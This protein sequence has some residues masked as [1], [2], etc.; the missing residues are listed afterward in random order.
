MYIILG[1]EVKIFFKFPFSSNLLLSNASNNQTWT[2]I[3]LVLF[4]FLSATISSG[5]LVP[6]ATSFL[7]NPSSSFL[8]IIKILE[9]LSFYDFLITLNLRIVKITAITTKLIIPATFL[10]GGLLLCDTFLA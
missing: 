9:E 10:S 6:T 3:L 2:Q 1:Q 8:D 5:S 4:A 7:L